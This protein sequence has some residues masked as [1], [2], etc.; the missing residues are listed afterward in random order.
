MK[1]FFEHHAEDFEEYWLF[2]GGSVKVYSSLEVEVVVHTYVEVATVGYIR[3]EVV[4]IEVETAVQ[5]EAEHI[6]QVLA[7]SM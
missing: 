2:E 6:S 4:D 7:E 3:V 5:Y 1:D